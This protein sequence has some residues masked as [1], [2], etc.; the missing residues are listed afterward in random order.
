MT[1][2]PTPSQSRAIARMMDQ[3]DPMESMLLQT[4][5]LEEQLARLE[6]YV[7]GQENPVIDM[8]PPPAAIQQAEAGSWERNLPPTRTLSPAGEA[9]RKESAEQTGDGP[10]EVDTVPLVD[11]AAY[12]FNAGWR[13]DDLVQAVAVQ[14]AEER[15]QNRF[16]LGD[17]GI[18]DET[19]GP[20]R[21]LWQIRTLKEPWQVGQPEADRFRTFEAT[22]GGYDLYDPQTN[23]DAAY[24]L[25]KAN[26]WQPWSVTHDSAKGT[27]N[28]YRNFIPQ[29]REAVAELNRILGRAK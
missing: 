3:M 5:P 28:D 18:Q 12:A 8:P 4:A 19:F 2:S 21:G 16:S 24:Q 25:W 7:P 26:K 23:A 1:E 6:S 11:V 14:I 29:A 17:Y 27:K 10:I 9:F 13:G 20:S 15:N 22:D